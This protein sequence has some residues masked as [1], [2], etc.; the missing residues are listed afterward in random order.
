MGGGGRE[1]GT[2]NRAQHRRERR[3][4][5]EDWLEGAVRQAQPAF[6]FPSPARG[7]PSRSL[8]CEPGLSG[9]P[10]GWAP[11]VTERVGLVRELQAARV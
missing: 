10:I 3:S 6:A 4:R 8:A 9:S 11:L 5:K 1:G 2:Q 7:S